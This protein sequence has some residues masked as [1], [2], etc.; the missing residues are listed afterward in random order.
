MSAGAETLHTFCSFIV[1]TL[2]M[3]SQILAFSVSV[4]I[5]TLWLHVCSFAHVI[6]WL[7]CETIG[8]SAPL[9]HLYKLITL[10]LLIEHHHMY[11]FFTDV[12][13]QNDSWQLR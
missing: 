9:R 5:M 8:P 12:L 13:F 7:G 3:F 2:I 11:F 10:Q 6:L 1:A 4:S